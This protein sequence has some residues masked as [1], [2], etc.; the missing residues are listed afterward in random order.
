MTLKSTD[1]NWS[2]VS[3]FFHWL[4]VLLILGQGT[5][6]LLMGE[7]AADNTQRM[8]LVGLHKSIGFLILSLAVLRLLWRLYAGAPQ[9]VPETP[10]WQRVAAGASH[11]LLYLLLLLI[12]IS[13]WVMSSAAGGFNQSFF[14]LFDVPSLVAQDQARR[15]GAGQAHETLF[16]I[17][18]FVAAMHAAAAFYHHLFQGDATLRRMLPGGRR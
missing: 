13:G 11:G 2:S 15:E 12:P 6:G 4:I 3:K 1:D 8:Q 17:L 14:G 16:W 9:P 10:R 5:F 7:L 18:V